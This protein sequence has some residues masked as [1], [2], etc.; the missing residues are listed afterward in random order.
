MALLPSSY[1]DAVVSIGV[2]AEEKFRS[3]ATGFLVGFLNGEKNKDGNLSHN[4]FLVTNRH[5][6][7]NRKQILLRFNLAAEDSK[8][9]NIVLEDDKGKPLWL[10]HSNKKI[11]IAMVSLNTNKL[12]ADGIKYSFIKERDIAFQDTIQDK[13]ISQGDGIFVLGFPMGISG[14]EKNYVIVRSGIISRLDDE[15]IKTEQNFLIDST[16]FPGNS[17]GPVIL[18]PE[19]ASLK[20]TKAVNKAYLIGVVSGYLPYR[21]KA[22]SEQTGE[23]RIIFVENSGIAT[24]VPMDF[25]RDTIR[26][27]MDF[28]TKKNRTGVAESSQKDTKEN[29]KVT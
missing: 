17:G 23:V 21:E 6:F 4:V 28:F 20:G 3:L 1:L 22:R 16:I 26:P 19:L 27:F 14:R 13:G 5:V 29:K 7:E 12:V 24:V 11:D 9:Y 2:E 10:A 15:I 25:V 18:K 8:K